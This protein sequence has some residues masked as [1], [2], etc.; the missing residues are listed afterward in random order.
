MKKILVAL[1]AVVFVVVLFAGCGEN[2]EETTE[3]PTEVIETTE[4]PTEDVTEQPVTGNVFENKFISVTVPEGWTSNEDTQ[5][6]S[7]NLTKDGELKGV[8]ISFM[9]NIGITAEN[10]AEGLIQ[11]GAGG[12]AEEITIGEN[13]YIKIV[14]KLGEK[15]VTLLV[16]EKNS[17]LF[18]LTV[19]DFAGADEQAILGSLKLK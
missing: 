19:D 4:N 9:E 15:E 17:V 11:G 1:L 18:M 6:G 7:V 2:K 3:N 13:G 8:M 12:S 5:M 10:Y 16:A 14:S